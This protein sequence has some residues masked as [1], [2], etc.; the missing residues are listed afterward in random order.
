MERMYPWNLHGIERTWQDVYY[1]QERQ[2]QLGQYVLPAVHT[3]VVDTTCDTTPMDFIGIL[4]SAGMCQ[5]L[6]GA[7]VT[8]GR[9]QHILGSHTCDT[10]HMIHKSYLDTHGRCQH[11]NMINWYH[12]CRHLDGICQ[13]MLSPS[14]IAAHC[15]KHFDFDNDTPFFFEF[16]FKGMT[17]S[18]MPPVPRGCSHDETILTLLQLWLIHSV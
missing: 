4:E 2:S 14:Q 18:I 6:E 3:P 11:P 9:C 8:P 7:V 5:H 10:I 17:K 16:Y 13:H 15:W 12:R 1:F